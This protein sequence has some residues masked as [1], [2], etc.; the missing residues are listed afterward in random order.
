MRT[1]LIDGHEEGFVFARGPLASE[2]MYSVCAR[3]IS[4]GLPAPQWGLRRRF[5]SLL[6]VSPVRVNPRYSNNKMSVGQFRPSR[7]FVSISHCN[8]T[9]ADNV[10]CVWLTQHGTRILKVHLFSEP[11]IHQCVR[12]MPRCRQA[13]GNKQEVRGMLVCSQEKMR[14]SQA[15]HIRRAP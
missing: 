12:R 7:Q 2:L 11:A 3:C 5:E 15:W 9:V 1:G 4:T 6:G 8:N 13:A 14:V 10:F